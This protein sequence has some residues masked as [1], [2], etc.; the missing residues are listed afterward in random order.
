MKILKERTRL[1]FTEYNEAEKRYLEDLVAS[2]D[3]V[4]M[5]EDPDGMKLGLPTG[6]EKSVR[7]VFTRAEFTDNSSSFW[8]YARIQPVEHNA[9]PRNQLQYDFIDF[10]LENVSKR[11][12]LAGILGPGTGKTF[13]AIY[14]AIK[15]GIRT[16]IIA[17]TSGIKQQWLETITGM[18]QVPPERAKFVS[19]PSDLI[20]VN[21]DFVIVSQASLAVLNKKY[22]LERILK[23]GKFGIKIVDEA[24]M[25]FKNIVCV[26]SCSNI[27]N[28]W[29]LTG[30][31]GRSGETEN[32]IFQEMFGDLAIFREKMKPPTLFDP[33]P[34]NIYGMKP[35]IHTKMVW[36]SSRL[37]KETIKKITSSMRYSEREGKWMRFGVSIPMWA[38]TVIPSDYSITPFLKTVL[39]VVK[40]AENEVPYGKTL[41]LGPTVNNAEIVAYYLKKILP[42]K[43]IGTYH[44]RNSKEEN[45]R[46]KAECDILV[47]TDKSAGTGFDVK[48]LGKLILFSQFKSWILAEQIMFR[49]R[50]RDD[51]KDCY[52]WDIVD[53]QIPQ[54]RSWANVRADVYKKKGKT[55]K[56]IDL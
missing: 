33:R 9:Q 15:A 41:V 36:T 12:K 14:S 18:F 10:V 44:S 54:L 31:F 21:H 49:N 27:A 3:N 4:Y 26:D 28:N 16:L 17:P 32:R 23:A 38:S 7:R 30:T 50:R 53:S 11:Q 51:N 37:D 46:N 22:D 5:Y 48:G 29:Y 34:G 56:V 25:W 39:T 35:Y 55:F 13:M 52:F 42:D 19:K 2:M 20:N 40:R 8:D 47:S 6:M 43:K 45:A 24:Q 1:I